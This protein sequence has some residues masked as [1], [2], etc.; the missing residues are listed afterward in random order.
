MT[1][2]QS[3]W[4]LLFSQLSA[5]V[6]LNPLRGSLLVSL[7][8]PRGKR[9]W[10]LPIAMSS[11]IH[12]K[13]PTLPRGTALTGTNWERLPSLNGQAISQNRIP[14]IV[15]Q[16]VPVCC[17]KTTSQ[18]KWVKRFAPWI[19]VFSVSLRPINRGILTSIAPHFGLLH[20]WAFLNLYLHLLNKLRSGSLYKFLMYPGM[21]HCK[22]RNITGKMVSKLLQNKIR[23][24]EKYRDLYSYLII[25]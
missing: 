18:T 11:S 25:I 7:N 16:A 10:A 21:G 6:S 15:G 19:R 24:N 23:Y 17:Y 14:E 12:E 20:P 3:V 13:Q 9:T 4:N 2:F 5:L 22:A 8:L 1:I